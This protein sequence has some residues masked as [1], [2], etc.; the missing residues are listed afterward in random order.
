[1]KLENLFIDESGSANPKAASSGLYIICGCMANNHSRE[2]LKVIADQIKFKFWDRTNIVFHSREIWR[3]EGDFSIL[4]DPKVNKHFYKH[5]FSFLASGGFQV[6]AVAVDHKEAA[7]RNWNSK[8]V[9]KETSK[10]IVKNFILSLVASENRG[11]LVIESAASE[12]DFNFHKAAG[13]YLANGIDEL[14]I[15]CH[16]VQNLLT[17]ISF[18]RSAGVWSK[19]KISEKEEIKIKRVR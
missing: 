16:Q 4:K 12:T 2:K 17:E 19:V 10:I 18:R 13:H 7:K 9:Y 5:L 15:S 11:R 1:M 14:D 6:F 8:K 3:K